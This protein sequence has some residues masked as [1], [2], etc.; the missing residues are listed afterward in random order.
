MFADEVFLTRKWGGLP[1]NLK[2]GGKRQV[3]VGRTREVESRKTDEKECNI[4]G[5][6]WEGKNHEI[7]QKK[8]TTLLER[9]PGQEELNL[10]TQGKKVRE[11]RAGRASAGGVTRFYQR[12]LLK[13]RNKP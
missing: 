8:A 9:A 13:E 6:N 4:N 12:T 3:Q 1:I 7:A 10:K 5:S 2:G 11:R